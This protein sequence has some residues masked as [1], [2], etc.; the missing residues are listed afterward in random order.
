MST[1]SSLSEE[2]IGEKYADYLRT[3]REIQKASWKSMQPYLAVGLLLFSSFTCAGAR[4]APWL[5]LLGMGIAVIR[6][7]FVSKWTEGRV[8]TAN[9]AKPG[10]RGFFKLHRDYYWTKELPSGKKLERFLSLIG[11]KRIPERIPKGLLFPWHY[12][13]IAILL[14]IGVT[15]VIVLP[16]NRP[17][18]HGIWWLMMTDYSGYYSDHTIRFSLDVDE[19]N[20]ISGRGIEIIYEERDPDPLGQDN[21]YVIPRIV[22]WIYLTGHYEEGRFYIDYIT[23]G[24]DDEYVHI[25]DRYC[26]NVFDEELYRYVLGE[27]LT[28]PARLTSMLLDWIPFHVGVCSIEA[29][30]LATSHC[31]SRYQLALHRGELEAELSLE[32]K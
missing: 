23:P 32:M 20:R 2:E 12:L 26:D 17:T 29:K 1:N 31:T 13:S 5:M 7:V 14:V 25:E 6:A 21:C 18:V 27:S 11:E 3:S 16:S 15:S 24:S 4:V 19:R 22:G 10:F 9:T 30:D 8:S 28:G